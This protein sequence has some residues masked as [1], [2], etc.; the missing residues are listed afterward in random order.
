MRRGK[1]DGLLKI[2]ISANPLNTQCS[3]YMV[4]FSSL[5]HTRSAHSQPLMCSNFFIFFLM[6]RLY[7]ILLTIKSFYQ[8]LTWLYSDKY[9]H[10]L[11]KIWSL[12]YGQFFTSV[13]FDRNIFIKQWNIFYQVIKHPKHFFYWAM[14]H[15]IFF[16]CFEA[17]FNISQIW[18]I[19]AVVSSGNS[20]KLN[21][22]IATVL[23]FD[24]S[25][26]PNQARP[27]VP[28]FDNTNIYYI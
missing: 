20:N 22:A 18:D 25:K 28:K 8:D 15:L 26:I 2:S 16:I 13:T 3:I 5:L 4:S 21:I 9:I 7:I 10:M 24:N 11:H 19:W 23:K 6:I 17:P 1:S 12:C 14:K 27:S